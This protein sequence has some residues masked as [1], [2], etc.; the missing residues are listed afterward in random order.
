MLNLEDQALS[1]SA[2]LGQWLEIGGKRYGHVIDPRTGDPLGRRR[3]ALVIA[4]DATLAEA[5]STALLV[6]GADEGIALVAQLPG[7][8]ALLLDADGST[9]RTPGWDDAVG[10]EVLPSS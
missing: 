5:L 3:Q 10:F 6:L 7:C 8:E 9:W 2:S 1:V 4:P